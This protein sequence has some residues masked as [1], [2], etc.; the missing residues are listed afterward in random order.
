[1]IAP[2]VNQVMV[3]RLAL[4]IRHA[5]KKSAWATVRSARR[6]AKKVQLASPFYAAHAAKLRA[7]ADEFAELIQGANET[8]RELG[9]TLLRLAKEFDL[10]TTLAQ[11]CD[12]LNVNVVDRA[13]LPAN[14]GL[15]D[16]IFIHGL[17]DSV[18][19]RH[20][21]C[22]DGPLFTAIQRAM[23]H[24]M[25]NTAAGRIAMDQAFAD[26]FGA[27]GLFGVVRARKTPTL[28]LVAHNASMGQSRAP[29]PDG[30]AT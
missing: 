13:N 4:R 12:L 27:G 18:M 7:D 10:A 28:S 24:D 5:T 30:S 17:E 9:R 25:S 8:Y 2:I 6:T 19:R 20:E 26:V 15:V 3:I 14:C 29:E 1:M 21:D 22:N 23:I 11:R 16:L